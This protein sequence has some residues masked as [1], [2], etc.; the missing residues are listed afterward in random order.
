MSARD[1]Q[2]RKE[3]DMGHSIT[4]RTATEQ[5]RGALARLAALDEAAMPSG[6]ALLA[7]VDGEPMA[8]LPLDGG[9]PVADPFHRTAELVALL[10]MRAAQDADGRPSR[11]RPRWALGL[12]RA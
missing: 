1:V 9:A 5:D 4:I 10:E 7:L 11:A 8:A 12:A 2:F 6:D 3:A